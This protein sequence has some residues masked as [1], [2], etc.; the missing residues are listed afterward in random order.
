MV[1]SYLG[2]TSANYYIHDLVAQKAGNRAFHY[3]SYY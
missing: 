3:T 2:G 1:I